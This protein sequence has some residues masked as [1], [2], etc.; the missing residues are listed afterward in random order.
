MAKCS[1]WGCPNEAQIDG[2]CRKHFL[3]DIH[4]ILKK[5]KRKRRQQQDEE[6][7]GEKKV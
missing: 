2:V 3:E 7:R 6:K 1:V 5:G 4:L